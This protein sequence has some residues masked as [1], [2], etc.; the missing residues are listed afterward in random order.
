MNLKLK[1]KSGGLEE[2]T[3][4]GCLPYLDFGVYLYSQQVEEIL[5]CALLASESNPQH[6]MLYWMEG[7]LLIYSAPHGH[8]VTVLSLSQ[9]HKVRQTL[10]SEYVIE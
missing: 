8:E 1:Y 4:G 10:T 2:H 7:Q 5:G 9:P 3:E 6:P